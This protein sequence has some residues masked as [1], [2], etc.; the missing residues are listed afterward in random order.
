MATAGELVLPANSF[1]GSEI[2]AGE[3]QDGLSIFAAARPRL[4]AIAYRMLGNAAEAEDIV[5]DVWLRWQSA[6][7]NAVENPPAFLAKTTARLCINLA[8]A[9]HSRRETCIGTWLPEPADPSG[10]PGLYAERG[11]ALKLALLM[12]LEKLSPTERAAFILREAFDYSYRE[13]AD[14][15][16]LEQANVR[17]LVSR[18]RK[19]IADDRLTSVSSEEQRRFLKAFIAAAQKGDMDGLETLFIEDVVA[20]WN[21]GGVVRASSSTDPGGKR[22]ATLTETPDAV[23]ATP[24]EAILLANDV[25]TQRTGAGAALAARW[26]QLDNSTAGTEGADMAANLLIVNSNPRPAR[27]RYYPSTWLVYSQRREFR[28]CVEHD[29]DDRPHVLGRGAA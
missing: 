29:G 6:N 3:H 4:F 8:Q 24:Q 27:E 16:Q 10:D 20:S 23:S 5:Q 17:Q 25:H 12:L 13:I 7:Q 11:E 26:Q 14:I 22:S 19:H 21:G 1:L 15:L 28:L 2:E 18:A 9:A